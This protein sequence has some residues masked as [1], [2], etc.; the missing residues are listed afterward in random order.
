MEK[1][2]REKQHNIKSLRLEYFARKQKICEF[3]LYRDVLKDLFLELS[4]MIIEGWWFKMPYA[5]G[6]M[7]IIKSKPTRKNI[8][9]GNTTK[10]KK[11]GKDITAVHL[12]LDTE[13]NIFRWIWERKNTLCAHSRMWK[14][15]N[16]RRNKY[17]IKEMVES[18][19]VPYF[20][21]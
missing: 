14:W 20:Q 19:P 1:T 13:G 9:W 2:K 3:K 10:L 7:K 21:K 16:L 6:T 12:N 17:N 11:K 15:R 5:L 8:D 18:N 4:I